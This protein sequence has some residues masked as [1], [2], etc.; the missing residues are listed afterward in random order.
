MTDL[1]GSDEIA[2]RHVLVA[3]RRT[4]QPQLLERERHRV[5]LELVRP[6]LAANVVVVLPGCRSLEEAARR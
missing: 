5:A 1:D 2:A 3:G 6:W 4:A